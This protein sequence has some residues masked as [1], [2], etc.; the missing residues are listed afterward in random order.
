MRFLNEDANIEH[1]VAIYTDESASE[2][3]FV[4]DRSSDRRRQI[5][6]TGLDPGTYYF[7]CDLHPQM[8][9]TLE[10]G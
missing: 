7:R 3:L 10:V 9:G 1:N 2:S 6:G 4:G 5:R 8:D